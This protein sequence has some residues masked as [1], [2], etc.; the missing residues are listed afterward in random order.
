MR[1]NRMFTM[2]M[3]E[4]D[5]AFIKHRADKAQMDMTGY[6]TA[7]A[8]DKKIVVV[9]GLDKV[10]FELKAIGR[11]L[12]QLTTLCNMGKIQCL[13]L[14]QVRQDFGAVFDRLY[15]LQDRS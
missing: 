15:D 9:D 5:Y 4:N 1:K 10:L 7:S 11:N 2:R 12:N 6:L 13:D 3:S 8:L 14:S